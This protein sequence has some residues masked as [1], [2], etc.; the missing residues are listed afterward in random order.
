M[1][2]R[3]LD[4]IFR[5]RNESSARAKANRNYSATIPMRGSKTPTCHIVES[6]IRIYVKLAVAAQIDFNSRSSKRN[7]GVISPR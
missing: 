6:L 2:K 3:N 5:L 4:V 1:S 7:I